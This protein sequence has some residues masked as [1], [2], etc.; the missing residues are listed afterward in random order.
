MLT[1]DNIALNHK[2]F[3]IFEFIKLNYSFESNL[4]WKVI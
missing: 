3:W 1:I 4:S 2:I